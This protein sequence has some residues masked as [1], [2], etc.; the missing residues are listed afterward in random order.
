MIQSEIRREEGGRE[1]EGK[2]SSR[3]P[4][5]YDTVRRSHGAG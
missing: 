4:T 2:A 3:F 1:E 5:L